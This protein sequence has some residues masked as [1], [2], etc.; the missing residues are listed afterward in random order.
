M[1]IHNQRGFTLVEL[2]IVVAV[3]AILV[4]IA[5]PSYQESVIKSK[6]ADAKAALSELSNWME[7]YYTANG[8]YTALVSGACVATSTTPPSLPFA[9]TPRLGTANYTLAPVVTSTSYTLTATPVNNTDPCGA[10]SLDSTG[11]KT[12][13]ASTSSYNYNSSY[14][15]S[16]CW[17]GN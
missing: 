17:T 8:C 10:L 15:A 13:T 2:M 14:T 5:Y 3:V 6:R 1:Q 7:R 12:I 16:Y 11:A 4:R 9:Q